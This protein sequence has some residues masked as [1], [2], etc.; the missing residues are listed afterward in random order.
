MAITRTDSVTNVETILAR[1]EQEPVVANL[2]ELYIH[3]FTDFIDL[4]LGADGR[5][6]YPQLSLYWTERGRYPFLVKVDGN[7]A[8]FALV[9]KG[10]QISGS[11]DVWDV[12]EFF[13][14]RGYRRR[15]IGIRVAQQLW[16]QYPGKWEV[17]VIGRNEKAKR[18]WSRAVAE[19]AGTVI[20]PTPFNKN[21]EPWHLFSF[22]SIH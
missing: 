17:R 13:I 6:G 3:D 4:E 18:F 19:F 10:S 20:D 8:G 14:A 5:F 7:L 1:P 22:E 12:T 9:Q 11:E 21:G 2:L 16:K 15:G